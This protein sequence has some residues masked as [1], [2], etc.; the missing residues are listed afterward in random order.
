MTKYTLNY[1]PAPGRAAAIRLA[2]RVAG[3]EFDD[4]TFDYFQD[5]PTI[6]SDATRFPLGVCPTL[7]FDGK[8]L[9]QSLAILR[10]VASEF[11]L[12]G[13]NN[14]QKYQVDMILDTLNDAFG[15]AEPP[16]LGFPP[17]DIPEKRQEVAAEVVAKMKLS[18]SYLHSEFKKNAEG[19]GFLVGDKLTVADLQ[20]YCALGNYS[21]LKAS[22]LDE[23]PLFKAFHERI[24]SM[25]QVKDHFAKKNYPAMPPI[26]Q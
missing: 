24:G 13:S 12:Y 7:Q 4:V 2:F 18:F 10:Y 5:W 25:P 19:K 15:A 22:F 26:L 21:I 17:C 14:V 23:Y 3:V 8:T 9:T 16:L 11:G 20:M 6:K 1:F